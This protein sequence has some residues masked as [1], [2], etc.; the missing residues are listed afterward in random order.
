MFPGFEKRSPRVSDDA[1]SC[2]RAMGAVLHD[3]RQLV[4]NQMNIGR[5]RRECDGLAAELDDS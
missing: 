4:R 1:A 3:M 5:A 2:S